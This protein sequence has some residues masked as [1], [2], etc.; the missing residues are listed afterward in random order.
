MKKIL[1]FTIALV[2]GV[3]AFTSCEG[4]DPKQQYPASVYDGIWVS[5]SLFATNGEKTTDALMWEI[6]NSEQIVFHSGDTAKWEVFNEHF[7]TFT[8]RDGTKIEM[9]AMQGDEDKQRV[10]FSV[11]GENLDRMGIWNPEITTL[12]MYRLPK[13]EGKKLP[14]NEANLLGKWR[15]TYEINTDYK[16]ILGSTSL[17][18]GYWQMVNGYESQETMKSE[19]IGADSLD[20]DG[21][22]YGDLEE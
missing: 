10:S 11:W 1:F 16:N 21:R 7:F 9:E 15:T 5:D 13:P 3:L 18:F 19:L 4:N 2:T 22:V 17:Q 14:V 12:Y 20:F 8:F 6:L